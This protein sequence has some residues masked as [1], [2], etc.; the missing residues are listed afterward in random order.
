MYGIFKGQQLALVVAVKISLL[1][2][3]KGW[4]NGRE[5]AYEPRGHEFESYLI[6]IVI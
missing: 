1:I 5:Q 6:R 3:I 2:V 4:N